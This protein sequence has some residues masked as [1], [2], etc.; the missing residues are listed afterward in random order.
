MA[1]AESAS[2][3]P[4]R[5]RR[6]PWLAAAGCRPRLAVTRTLGLLG[7]G[8][9]PYRPSAVRRQRRRLHHWLYR[10][11]P[12]GNLGCVRSIH[13]QHDDR[14]RAAVWL[15]DGHRL[16]LLH[17]DAVGAGHPLAPPQLCGA[18]NCLAHGGRQ[19][20]LSA[21]GDQ[22]RGDHLR[23]DSDLRGDGHRRRTCDPRGPQESPPARA[24][25]A[26]RATLD[27]AAARAVWLWRAA[28]HAAAISAH[29]APTRRERSALRRALRRATVPAR[30][31]CARR[32]ASTG[33][34]TVTL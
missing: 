18:G 25:P 17:W 12:W 22:C 28:E 13:Q 30:A 6:S 33:H 2:T 7:A 9:H 10:S 27:A 23:V 34:A 14:A 16:L 5:C 4:L 15:P 31:R 8:A 3:S 1:A 29:N 24:A 21:D 11:C 19:L 26:I 20:A 32:G